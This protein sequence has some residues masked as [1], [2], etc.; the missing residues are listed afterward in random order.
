M[1]KL[2]HRK[3]T[4]SQMPAMLAATPGPGSWEFRVVSPTAM[5]IHSNTARDHSPWN[6]ARDA[7]PYF[8]NDGYAKLKG[9]HVLRQLIDF[10]VTA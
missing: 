1:A 10:G 3:P 5:S 8:G 2:S 6:I 4:K 7:G 9:G